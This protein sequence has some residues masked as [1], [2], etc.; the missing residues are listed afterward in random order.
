MS[1]IQTEGKEKKRETMRGGYAIVTKAFDHLKSSLTNE[2][3]RAF[4][5]S[6]LEDVREVVR[7]IQQEQKAR[8]MRR[9]EPMLR[10]LE[11]YASEMDT[12]CQGARTPLS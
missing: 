7:K 3:S 5:D 2:D 12:F 4:S 9:I 6:T 10:S 11:T 8:N 1:H